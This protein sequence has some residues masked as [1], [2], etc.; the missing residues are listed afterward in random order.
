[1]RNFSDLECSVSVLYALE[2][3]PLRV[4]GNTLFED[5]ASGGRAAFLVHKVLGF[6]IRVFFV[7]KLLQKGS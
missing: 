2:S 6:G 3:L 5:R 7:H 1:M 4:L